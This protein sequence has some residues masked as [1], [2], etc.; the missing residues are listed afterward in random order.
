MEYTRPEVEAAYH[1]SCRY[2]LEFLN[3][4]LKGDAAGRQFLDRPPAQ[5]GVPAHTA[6]LYHLPAPAGSVPTQAGFAAALSREGFGH[7]LEVYRRLQR[8]EPTFALSEGA[9]NTWGYQLLRNAHDLPAAQAMF[10]FGTELYPQSA[11]LFDSLGEV[12]ENSHDMS[13]AIQHYRRS[14]ELN[15]ANSNAQQRLQVLTA[16]K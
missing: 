4:T 5:N 10:R 15:P 7:A 16:A 12:D 3:A 1:W 11:N 14:L 9:I 6:L 13:A 8:Q 2:A